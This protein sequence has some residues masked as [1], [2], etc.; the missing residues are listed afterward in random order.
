MSSSWTIGSD[1]ACDVAVGRPAVSGRHCRLT[2]VPGG[3]LLEDL[4]S[5]NGTFVNGQR[6]TAPVRVTRADAVTLGMVQPLPWPDD[7]LVI[8]AAAAAAPVAAPPLPAAGPRVVTIGREPD[9]DV[10]VD[11]PT[12]SGHH[13]RVIWEGRPGEAVVEDA[14]S[15]N[16]TAVGAPDRKAA[17]A[18]V[19]A[20]DTIYLGTHP[21]PAARVFEAIARPPEVLTVGAGPVVVG[22]DP[23]CDRVVDRPAVSSRHARLTPRDDGSVVVEDLGSAN[24]TFVNGRRV[25]RVGTARAGDTVALGGYALVLAVAPA[26]VP[27]AGGTIPIELDPDPGSAALR[28]TGAA[29]AAGESFGAAVAAEWRAAWGWGWVPAVLLALG[30][31]AGVLAVATAGFDPAALGDPAG[32]AGGARALAAL[33]SRLGLAAVVVGL[34]C[35]A[36]AGAP[37]GVGLR[38][39]LARASVPAGLCAAGCLMAWGVFRALSGVGPGAGGPAALGLLGLGAGAALALGLVVAALAPRPAVAWAAA[40]ALALPLWA[41][42]GEGTAWPRLPGW[43][44]AAAGLNPSRW[45]FEGLLLVASDRLPDPAG[46]AGGDLAEPYFP[47]ETDR[48]GPRAATFVLAAMLLGWGAAAAF[49]AAAPTPARPGP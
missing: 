4:G 23:G 49:I 2:A 13:A 5:T 1:P 26:A 31:L 38:R 32:R 7:P 42:G 47:A 12:V 8:A 25:E 44:K 48:S 46:A 10:V 9:N 41:L 35:G 27:A 24:G 28:G 3:Y 14:G 17:R 19:R 45:T 15:S 36:V 40:A 43:A 6:V 18:V 30:P 11:L 33:V 22:R 34:A 16:G 20:S 21:L 29:S 37:A 39:W